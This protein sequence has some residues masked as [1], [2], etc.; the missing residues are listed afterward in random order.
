LI[1]SSTTANEIVTF[2]AALEEVE[3]CTVVTDT[4]TTVIIPHQGPLQMKF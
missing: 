3:L 2:V 1:V 4:G